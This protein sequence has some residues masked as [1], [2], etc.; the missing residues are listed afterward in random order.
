MDP[1]LF[2]VAVADLDRGDRE[3]DEEIPVEWLAKALEG[4][5]ATPRGTP[6]RVEVSLSKSGREVMVRGH[7]RAAVTMPCAR[8]LDPVDFDLDADMFLLLTPAAP[9]PSGAAKGQ[10]KP[11]GA[12]PKDAAA[13][14]KAPRV[15]AGKPGRK[16][17]DEGADLPDDAAA[18]D[19]YD[20]EKVA[21]DRFV[22]EFL[23]LELPMV[24]L[25]EDLRSEAS[26]ALER[27][28]ERAEATRS[29]REGVD[30]RLAPLAA[31]ASRLR[32]KK[33]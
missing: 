9:A 25:R 12:A 28:P 30:P 22:R 11:K 16:K 26:P 4:T 32:D 8:T 33:E 14:D 20:G 24:P 21:L 23:V 6:G 13:K 7:A 5:E 18:H 10:K 31:I 29:T 17:A 1:A 3:L 15:G 27:P 2:S 19:T